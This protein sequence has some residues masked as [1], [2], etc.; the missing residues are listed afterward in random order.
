[1]IIINSGAYVIPEL[2]AEYGK[3]PP[4]M[5]PLGNKRLLEHQIVAIRETLD[6]I[7]IVVSLPESYELSL[8]DN[9]LIET[10][11]VKV[12]RVPDGFTLAESVLYVLNT[13]DDYQIEH[14][15]RLMHGDTFIKGIPADADVIGVSTTSDDYGWEYEASDADDKLIW[16]GFFS[17]SSP[18][19]LTQSLSL[20]RG[21]FVEAIRRYGQ[22]TPL[23]GK[24]VGA[25][26]DLGHV[27]TYFKSRAS[28]TTQ[29]AFNSLVI[30]D[31]L[32]TKKGQPN[33]KIQAEARWFKALPPA[34]KRYTPQLIDYTFDDQG[35]TFYCLEYLSLSPLN[36]VFVHGRN[37]AFFW[38]KVFDIFQ[39][40]FAR[41]R[42]A[43]PADLDRQALAN[44][45]EA[46]YGAKTR[47]RLEET[48]AQ[49]L[50]DPQAPFTYAGKP[51]PSLAELAETC[52]DKV[53]GL[54]IID[55]VLHGDVCFSNVLYDSR[56]ETIKIL[57]PRGM[58]EAGDFSIFG[59]QKYDLAKLAHSVIGLYD[60]IIAG[61]YELLEDASGSVTLDFHIDARLQQIQRSFMGTQF[62]ASVSV[63]Q[64][65]PCVVLLFISMIPLHADRPDRQLAMRANAYRIFLSYCHEE[66]SA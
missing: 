48:A 54:P 13:Q 17:F 21:N 25:W 55:S 65:M 2:Q 49:G 47:R 63:K 62:A 66:I 45:A 7:N 56:N 61:R 44:D 58:T 8:G 16:C 35:G 51:M 28:I 52:I 3:I 26:N 34:L 1:M 30:A 59:D 39:D 38:K 40:L 46:L 33:R 24:L 53:S 19:L 23:Q 18:R 27:N 36:E 37:P 29:R 14:V 42:H 57:D 5:L 9:L 60:L 31:G 32:V 43:L 41:M 20:A 10:A 12:V 50:I 11:G 4:C 64:I 6:D 15:V 22:K